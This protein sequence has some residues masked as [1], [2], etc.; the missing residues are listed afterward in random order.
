M[1][2]LPDE[3]TKR[4]VNLFFKHRFYSFLSVSLSKRRLY[5]LQ[6]QISFSTKNLTVITTK[7]L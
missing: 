2:F 4:E 5:R 1:H 6:I 7:F 3:N